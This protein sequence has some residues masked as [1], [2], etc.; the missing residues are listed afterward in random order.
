[1]IGGQSNDI[2]KYYLIWASDAFWIFCA[3]LL[4]NY[5]SMLG[6]D[7]ETTIL[8]W[9]CPL[10]AVK[11]IN[12]INKSVHTELDNKLYCPFLLLYVLPL[13]MRELPVVMGATFGGYLLDAVATLYA[14]P[15]LVVWMN[16]AAVLAFFGQAMAALK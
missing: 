7:T 1:V 12:Y 13:S 11:L 8:N 3:A 6:L 4:V 15:I 16:R 10:L 5:S 2:F 14:I 9:I